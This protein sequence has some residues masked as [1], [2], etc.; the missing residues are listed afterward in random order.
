MGQGAGGGV[1]TV[2]QWDDLIQSAGQKYNVDPRLIA[3]VVQVESSGNPNA[4]NSEFGATGLTQIIPDTAR[5]LGVDPKT[6]E[7]AIEGAAKLLDENLRRYGNAEQAILAYHGGTD[8]SKWGPKTQDYLRKITKQYGAPEVATTAPAVPDEFVSRFG[9]RPSA[10]SV[11]A[12]PAEDAA[13]AFMARFGPKPEPQS[14]NSVSTPEQPPQVAATPKKGIIDTAKGLVE[15]LG[16][17]GI[18]NANA[19]GRGIMD[20]LDAPSE[21]LAAGAEKSGL[22]G[23]LSD[24]GV[25]MPTYDQQVQQ[26]AQSRAA[27]NAANPDSGIQGMASRVGGNLIGTL[28]PIAGLEAG[29]VKGGQ[30]LSN[31]IGNPQALAA[32]GSFLRGQGGLASRVTYNAGQG[33]LGGALLS[34]GQPDTTL[35]ESASLGALL[36]GAV[37]IAAGAV[38][39]GVNAARALVDPFTESGQAR[40][41]QSILQRNAAGGPI[42]PDL[43]TYV[44]GSTPTLAQATANPM[45]AAMERQSINKSPVEFGAIKDQNNQARAQYFDTIRG[46]P[47]TLEAA[48][49][50]READAIPLLKA[51]MN[52]AGPADAAPVVKLIDDILA[53]PSGQRDSVTGALNRV[54]DKLDGKS[55]LQ[56]DPNQLY[57][58]R[59]SINDQLET[60][61][62][63]DNS[64]AQQASRELNEVKDALD[65]VI[66]KAA[67]GFSNYIA[68]Y[69]ELSKPINAQ[70]YLQGIDLTDTTGS[71]MLLGKVKSQ[72][73][74]IEKQRSSPGSNNAKSISDEQLEGLRN[75]QKDLLRESNSVMKGKSAGSNTA[76]NLAMDNLMQSSLPG[77]L[78]RLPL[79]PEGIGGALGWALGGP[80]GAGI[81]AAGGNVLRQGMAAQSPLIESRL[82]DLLTDPTTRLARSNGGANNSL[83]QKL[84]AP[85]G[86]AVSTQRGG[87]N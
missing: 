34:G 64:A 71:S 58:I 9:P 31:A 76:Q 23:L 73:E 72:I 48:T 65:A 42:T 7:G 59:K 46:T 2:S 51:A 4:Y 24:A 43:T 68:K 81:G 84:L 53:S 62:G 18:S 25:N 1:R 86:S 49:V 16:A 78:G 32:A 56:T 15:D 19:V 10:Q 8:Q 17:Q 80:A 26:N 39:G 70:R 52:G 5:R 69:A 40:V 55:G 87:N 35:G 11:A 27:Y 77:V 20:V 47:Q 30:A 38:R 57:G 61:S 83:L 37:P 28:A 74:R 66:T 60:V 29:L 50:K 75:I 22:T 82:I 14:V 85:T 79:A 13:S 63:R 67:P 21:W 6:P 12:A 41:A 54:K 36:G 44:P 45:L 3:S 33:A